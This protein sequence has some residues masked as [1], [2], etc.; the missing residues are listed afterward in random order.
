MTSYQGLL[1]KLET[2]FNNHLQVKKFGGEFREQMPNF[3][4]LDERYPLVYVVP[5]SETSR[6]RFLSMKWA[7]WTKS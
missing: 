2:F 7:F 3:S 4:T 1:N 5:T 6:P